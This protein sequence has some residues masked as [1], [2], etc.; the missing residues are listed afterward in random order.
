M[1]SQ[2]FSLTVLDRPIRAELTF[3]DEGVHV[4]LT[5][6]CLSHI[7][8]VTVAEAGGTEQTIDLPGHREAEVSRLWA[9]SLAARLRCRVAV[10]CG[11]HYDGLT[12]QQLKIVLEGLDAL[13][14]QVEAALPPEVL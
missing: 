2:V 7:G 13:L 5:G 6:G 1:R 4:L 3:L 10:T 11:I 8:S 14:R 9:A 12:R